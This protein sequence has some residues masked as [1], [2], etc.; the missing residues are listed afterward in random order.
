MRFYLEAG[1][2]E[3]GLSPSR[4]N[5]S[6]LAANRHLRDVLLAKGYSVHYREFNGGHD[7]INWRGTFADGLLLL[8]GKD[9]NQKKDK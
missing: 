8:E 1:L 6:L 7:Y 4:G 2:L 9:D 3:T 5:V